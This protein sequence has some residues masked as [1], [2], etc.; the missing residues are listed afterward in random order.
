MLTT[1][2]VVVADDDARS[3]GRRKIMREETMHV[4]GNGQYVNIFLSSQ[5]SSQYASSTT[6]SSEESTA[7]FKN[8][9]AH[10]SR[11]RTRRQQRK[12]YEPKRGTRR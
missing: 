10:K 11:E 5:L 12:G 6:S 1:Y 3:M 4:S 9:G 8:S 7:E 2:I